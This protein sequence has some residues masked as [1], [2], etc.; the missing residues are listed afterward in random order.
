[1]PREPRARLW[2]AFFA[3]YTIW[4]STYLAIRVAIETMPPFAM[5]SA[6]F[7]VAGLIL[8][9]WARRTGAPAPTARQWRS[10]A[11]VG[12]LLLVLGNGGVVWAEQRVTSGLA[13]LMIGAEPLWAVLFDW[14]RP[15]G[16]RPSLGV[17]F[18]LMTGFVGV[19]LLVSPSSMGGS[20]VEPVGAAVLVVA[21]LSWAI[22]SIYSRRADTPKSPLVTIGANMLAGGV[23]LALAALVNGEL[24]RIDPAAFTVRSVIAWAYLTLFGSIV[25]FSSYIWLLRHTT[26]AKASTYAYVN[27]VV[28]VFLGWLVLG[29]PVT[30]RTIAGAAVIIAGVVM[31]SAL[32]F[33]RGK[34]R[35]KMAAP[36]RLVAPEGTSKSDEE[37]ACS[38]SAP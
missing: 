33:L 8:Y 32:P 36:E 37:A 30:A 11:I 38:S 20:A 31:I 26:L 22:G 35:A 27:P 34:W 25:G 14:L 17:G 29:E 4:G 15:G 6:R 21:T 23:G 10:A 28:A 24:A 3:L 18:G 13:A 16:R 9:V 7:L 5:A 12:A 1:M 19:A 2:L